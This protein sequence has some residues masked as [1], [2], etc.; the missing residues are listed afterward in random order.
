[1]KIKICGLFNREDIDYVNE[2]GP[3]YVGFVFAESRRRIGFDAAR[4]YKK[5]LDSRI[6]CAGVFVNAKIDD[7][8]RLYCDDVIDMAQLHGDEDEAYAAALRESCGIPVIKAV[9][10]NAGWRGEADYLLFDSGKGTGKT[11]DWSKLPE[12]PKPF[13]LAGGINLDNIAEA[14]KLNPFCVDISGGAE[15]NGVKDREKII[16]LVKFVRGVT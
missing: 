13:F 6:K 12:Q 7:I 1:M 9:I 16:K 10:D 2:A 5:R 11:F 4:E 15:T 3:D 8:A 14:V